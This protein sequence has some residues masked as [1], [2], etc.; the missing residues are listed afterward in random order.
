MDRV[1]THEMCMNKE[2]EYVLLT[3][4][5]CRECAINL[6]KIVIESLIQQDLNKSSSGQ[7][8]PIRFKGSTQVTGSQKP[9]I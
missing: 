6:C 9:K 2:E 7:T 5:N 4:A 1:K 8:V 3:N